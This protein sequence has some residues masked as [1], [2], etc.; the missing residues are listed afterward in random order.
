MD[1][2]AKELEKGKLSMI[3]WV[4]GD[5]PSSASLPFFFVLPGL[6]PAARM[7]T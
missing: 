4:F 6:G 7:A 1:H 5:I 2:E 3:F